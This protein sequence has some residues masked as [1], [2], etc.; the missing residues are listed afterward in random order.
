MPAI[1][2]ENA[3]GLQATSYGNHEFDYG[4]E[5]LLE[6]QARANFPFLGANI[7]DESTMQNPEWVQGTHIFEYGDLRIGV[8]GIELK[9]TPELVSAGATAGLLFLD[10]AA[11]IQAESEKL[12]RQGMKI[13]IVL[14]HQGTA[15]GQN[16]VAGNP[17]VP[18]DGPI[19]TIAQAIQGTT[20]DVLIAGHTHRVSNV[21]V[22]K[23]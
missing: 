19:M 2:V 9:E 18:W 20:V 17:P 22:G 13:Q 8:I 15:N 23:I 3:W 16:A 11:T 5:R 1:D 12:R 4:V 6:H 14:I 7:V 21:M 10:E